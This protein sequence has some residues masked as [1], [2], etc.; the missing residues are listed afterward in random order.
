MQSGVDFIVTGSADKDFRSTYLKLP[1][2]VSG[3]QNSFKSCSAHQGDFYFFLRKV[4]CPFSPFS[5]SAVIKLAEALG[6]RLAKASPV[7]RLEGGHGVASPEGNPGKESLPKARGREKALPSTPPA[8]ELEA[9]G[10][11]TKKTRKPR[12]K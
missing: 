3:R 1:C 12:G 2:K 9:E 5:P 7:R 4:E 11:A 8:S 10:K 6:V